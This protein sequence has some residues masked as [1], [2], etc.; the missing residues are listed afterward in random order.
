MKNLNVKLKICK[1][2]KV[3]SNN[4]IKLY[5]IKILILR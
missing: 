2:F 4:I 5:A 1:I 3:M